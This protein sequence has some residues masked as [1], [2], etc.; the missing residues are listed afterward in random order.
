MQLNGVNTIFRNI[1]CVYN[2]LAYTCDHP[3]D[4]PEVRGNP[5]VPC[6]SSVTTGG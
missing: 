4:Q 1:R 5:F 6:A 2:A 3:Y